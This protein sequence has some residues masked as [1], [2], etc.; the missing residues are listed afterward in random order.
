ML[1]SAHMKDFYQTGEPPK[2]TPR[3][4]NQE[5]RSKDDFILIWLVLLGLTVVVSA[6]LVFKH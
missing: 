5:S 3:D 1:V 2:E 4:Q 6:Y